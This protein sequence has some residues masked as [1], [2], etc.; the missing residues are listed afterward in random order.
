[1]EF[2]VFFSS[3]SIDYS[4]DTDRCIHIFTLD[5]DLI[6]PCPCSSGLEIDVIYSKV[7]SSNVQDIF[8]IYELQKVQT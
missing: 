3:I 6:F 5:L 4:P 2:E 7:L 1:M 8:F